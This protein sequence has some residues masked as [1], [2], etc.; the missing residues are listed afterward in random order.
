MQT[1]QHACGLH[2]I[3]IK[4]LGVRFGEVDALYNVNMHVHCGSLNVVIGKNGAGKSTLVRAILGDVPHTG[5]IEFKNVEDG[6]LQ[7]LKI[8]YVP[9]TINIEENSPISVYDLFA[10][11]HD[12]FPLFLMKNK[13]AEEKFLQ[14]LRIFEAEHLIDRQLCK[15]SGGQM[16]RVMLAMAII[17]EPNLLLLDEPVSGVDKNGMDLFYHTLSRL[18][19]EFDL[20]I[21][22]ISHD[23]DYVKRFADHVILLDNTVTTQGTVEEVFTSESFRNIF[24]E[25]DAS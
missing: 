2:C 18:R 1:Y 14:A 23:L 8:G 17:D 25:G 19:K 9:Q 24:G 10:S 15:L 21:I 3:K 6:E 22:L 4:N 11:F 7:N 5:A 16:Q 13:K 12:K 20:S